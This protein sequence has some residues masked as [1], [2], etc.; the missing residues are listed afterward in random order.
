MKKKEVFLDTNFLLVP[1]Q[2]KL[3]IFSELERLMDYQL[4]IT[5]GTPIITELKKITK[6]KGKKGMAAK[7]ALKLIDVNKEH[8]K[9]KVLK[10]TMP[11]D[12]WIV[13]HAKESGAIICTNDILLKKRLFGIKARVISLKSK[14]SIGFV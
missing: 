5:T 11:A 10:G 6:N 1:L 7:F 4:E 9:I 12:D 2:F 14:S 8:G 3:D 13:E